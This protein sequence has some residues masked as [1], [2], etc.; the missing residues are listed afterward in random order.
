M[1]EDQENF[2]MNRPN[3]WNRPSVNV[4]D[5][6]Y[7]K[8]TASTKAKT[9]P[10]KESIIAVHISKPIRK[11]CE[12]TKT[13]EHRGESSTETNPLEFESTCSDFNKS[14]ETDKETVKTRPKSSASAKTRETRTEPDLR[15][16]SSCKL[17]IVIRSCIY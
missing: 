14:K 1:D 15:P 9:V 7:A 16:K 5:T 12:S 2:F 11:V 6:L 3:T 8:E 17:Y 13:C 4:F 10:K